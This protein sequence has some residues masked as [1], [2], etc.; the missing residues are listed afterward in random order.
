[1]IARTV[2]RLRL[3]RRKDGVRRRKD[4]AATEHRRQRATA[5]VRQPTLTG[6]NVVV[7]RPEGALI[8]TERAMDCEREGRR[9][10]P[11]ARKASG[12]L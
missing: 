5:P 7:Q 3:R 1:M 11:V 12:A 6:P 4:G 8:L 2:M 9:C 10:G